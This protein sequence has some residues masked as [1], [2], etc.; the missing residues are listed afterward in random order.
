MMKTQHSVSQCLVLAA[1]QAQRLSSGIG[2]LTVLEGR[3]WI[4]DSD[5]VDRVLGVG[6]QCAVGAAHDVVVEPWDRGRGAVLR[7]QPRARAP[8]RLRWREV[9]GAA[10]V[11][12][13][14]SAAS[15]ASRAQCAINACDSI[16][17]SGAVK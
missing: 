7:W 9:A 13:A 1:G 6:A 16:A 5:G 11:A 3:V 4:T 10:W 15:S 8:Q 14:R 2:V 12:L 17:S